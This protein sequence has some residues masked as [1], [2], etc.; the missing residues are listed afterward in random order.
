VRSYSLSRVHDGKVP[1]S[2]FKDKVVVIGATAPSLQ[3][4]KATPTGSVMSGPGVRADAIDT[5]MRGFPLRGL[6]TI[7]N[8]VLIVALGLIVPLISVRAGPLFSVG[9]GVFAFLL[10]SLGT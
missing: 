10:F 1:A 9:V 6:P 2:V 5:A 8:I 7:W 3:D 4:I